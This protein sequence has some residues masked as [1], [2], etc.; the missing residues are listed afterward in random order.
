M[1]AACSK[2]TPG[3]SPVIP[4]NASTFTG[5]YA[6]VT[7]GDLS[8]SKDGWLRFL[9]Q[10]EHVGASGIMDVFGV[11]TCFFLDGDGRE[12]GMVEHCLLWGPEF[13]EGKARTFVQEIKVPV[14]AKAVYIVVQWGQDESERANRVRIPVRPAR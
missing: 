4:T 13:R 8:W 12:V 5:P 14:P 2:V 1:L 7:V 10:I 11:A 3:F 6:R 9:Y